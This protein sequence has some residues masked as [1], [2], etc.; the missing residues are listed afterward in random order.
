MKCKQCKETK[1]TVKYI[2]NMQVIQ[3]VN[4]D[5]EWVDELNHYELQY[6]LHILPTDYLLVGEVDEF[7]TIS[8]FNH[9]IKQANVFILFVALVYNNRFCPGN[10]TL[11][12]HSQKDKFYYH[13]NKTWKVFGDSTV[14]VQAEQ[15]LLKKIIRKIRECVHFHRVILKDDLHKLDDIIDSNFALVELDEAKQNDYIKLLKLYLS[16]NI[17]YNLLSAITKLN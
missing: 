9:N 1:D 16:K 15:L 2:N 11:Y 7:N 5:N 6:N 13:N 3:L 17:E 4:F 8:M 10:R 12:Y 14:S